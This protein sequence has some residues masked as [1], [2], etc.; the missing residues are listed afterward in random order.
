MHD[1]VFFEELSSECIAA[2]LMLFLFLMYIILQTNKSIFG[3]VLLSEFLE[4]IS[5]EIK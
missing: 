5:Y 3:F 2:Y 4:A 1:W